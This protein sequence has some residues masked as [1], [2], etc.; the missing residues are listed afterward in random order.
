MREARKIILNNSSSSSSLTTHCSV[1]TSDNWTLDLVN[2]L[3][4]EFLRNNLF[5]L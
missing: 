1:S 3:N 2:L 4:I 5:P